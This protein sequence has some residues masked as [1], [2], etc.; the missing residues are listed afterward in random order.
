MIHRYDGRDTLWNLLPTKY[1]REGHASQ[2]V[3]T[4]STWSTNVNDLITDVLL[5]MVN[6]RFYSKK[7]IFDLSC[8][9]QVGWWDQETFSFFFFLEKL[10]IRIV[11]NDTWCINQHIL[12]SRNDCWSLT[13]P[14]G[15]SCWI[16]FWSFMCSS[17]CNLSNLPRLTSRVHDTADSSLSISSKRRSACISRRSLH[18]FSTSASFLYSGSFQYQYDT[19]LTPMQLVLLRA[20]L[21][22]RSSLQ[23]S[24]V[25][26]K[27][28]WRHD[29]WALDDRRVCVHHVKY[30]IILS[31][32]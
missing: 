27:K 3:D 17:A 29:S 11:F 31:L 10:L 2:T 8:R 12:M 1:L 32:N 28:L 7:H 22:L 14:D 23:W 25:C 24:S 30:P 5:S 20:V 6:E 18:Q 15:K 26:M 19:F 9:T 16:C 21:L 13:D 4:I